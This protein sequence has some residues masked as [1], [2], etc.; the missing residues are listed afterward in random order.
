MV[1]LS[2]REQQH[3][4]RPADKLLSVVIDHPFAANRQIKDIALHA[5]RTVNKEIKIAIG[6][7]L[8][9]GPSPDGR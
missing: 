2:R 9:S 7:Q 4:A 3:I 6:F 1:N 8:A 5:Q